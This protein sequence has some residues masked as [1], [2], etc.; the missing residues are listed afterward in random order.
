[1]L[2]S[3]VQK[4]AQ[5][6]PNENQIVDVKLKGKVHKLKI[7]QNRKETSKNQVEMFQSTKDL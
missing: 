5:K 6:Q 2:K 4:Y 7:K 3:V 1:M